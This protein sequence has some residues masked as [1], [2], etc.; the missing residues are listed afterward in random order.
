MRIKVLPNGL[1]TTRY[2][3]SITKT[4]GKA[5]V[6]NRV[7]RLL[8]EIIRSAPMKA[9]W[10]IVFIVRPSAATADYHQLNESARKLLARAYLLED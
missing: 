6:R 9:G 4:V 10:D 3:F 8:R 2:G 1:A 5:V 7:R